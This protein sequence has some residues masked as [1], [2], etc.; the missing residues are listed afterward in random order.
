MSPRF[1]EAAVPRATA[2]I[3]TARA[4]RLGLP[5]IGNVLEMLPAQLLEEVRTDAEAALAAAFPPTSPLVGAGEGGGAG[6]STEPPL[7]YP[8]TVTPALE[9]VLG[10]MN[11]HTG[12]VAHLF[13]DT[14]TAIA[15][16]TEAEQ[17]FVLHWLIKLALRHG[18][19][20]GEIAHAKITELIAIA[21]AA[22][23]EVVRAR[24]EE[25]PPC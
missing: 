13:R 14:G 9:H 6:P 10:L 2:A 4:A 1:D 8:E 25:T 24:V 5:P 17:A 3:A 22:E 7:A 11:F 20:W 19:G 23:A 15:R 21:R 16:K 18:D 12:P